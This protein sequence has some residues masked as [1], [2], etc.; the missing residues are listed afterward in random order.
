MNFNFHKVKK[1]QKHVKGWSRVLMCVAYM[2]IFMGWFIVLAN[3]LSMFFA[4]D[5]STIAWYSSD[6]YH[7]IKIDKGF[8][9]ISAFLKIIGS[10]YC[11]IR[12]GNEA[13]KIYKAIVGEYTE[14]EAGRTNGITMTERKTK[15]MRHHK[16]H[17]K[18]ITVV[19]LVILFLQCLVIK[20]EAT[21]KIDEYLTS[22]YEKLPLNATMSHSMSLYETFYGN[23]SIYEEPYNPI[24]DSEWD[25]LMTH[26]NDTFVPQ[27]DQANP[28]FM[29]VESTTSEVMPIPSTTADAITDDNDGFTK[30]AMEEEEKHHHKKQH[31]KML[32]MINK[33]F[34]THDMTETQAKN[35]FH[36]II[37]CGVII[38][39]IW[40]CSINIIAQ[41]I[42]I[43]L[44]NK[45]L[46]HQHHLEQHF[47]GPE[48]QSPPPAARAA[49]AIAVVAPE[50]EI[51]YVYAPQGQ[52]PM[53]VSGSVSGQR[54]FMV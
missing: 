23:D 8:L 11:L 31:N 33:V 2:L 53:Q 4:S 13:L 54:N 32:D 46:H 51:Q 15:Q 10:G 36:M 26:A 39:F 19:Q 22:E 42:Y 21:L 28:D 47:M 16:C 40:V 43:C 5:F 18:K 3:G 6:G 12:Q 45:A 38:G 49:E 48:A 9:I 25:Y 41:A 14:A 24:Q 34:D 30:D 29:P 44:V 1:H 35:H 17:V 20:R 50:P 7:Q 52:P 37:A 27:P